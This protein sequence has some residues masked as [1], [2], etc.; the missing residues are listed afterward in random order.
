MK[1]RKPS[2]KEMLS[3]CGD[4]GPDDGLDPRMFFRKSPRKRTNRKAL[5]LCGQVAQTLGHVLAWETADPALG[6][7]TVE[8]VVPAPD[9][10]RLLVTVAAPAGAEADAV[11]AHLHRTCGRLRAE[12]AAEIHRKRVPELT[13]QVVPRG[14][15]QP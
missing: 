14:E 9:S 2:R 3:C 15:V 1:S 12:V 13:F 7:L 5:Q 8:S 4:V 11:L 10:T 6:E